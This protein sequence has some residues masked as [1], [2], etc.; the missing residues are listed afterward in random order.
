MP[1][2]GIRAELIQVLVRHMPFVLA[3]LM[4]VAPF[5]YLTMQ[6]IRPER[7]QGIWL[8]AITCILSL[9]TALA[10]A[11][12]RGWLLGQAPR[13]EGFLLV[14]S[15]ASGAAFGVF[16]WLFPI[17][18]PETLV[19][20]VIVL[21]GL[22]SGSVASLTAVRGIYPAFALPAMGPLVL[23][24][25]LL[26]GGFH[27]IIG[28]FGAM[29][30]LVN[31]GYS[32]NQHRALRDAIILRRDRE[33]IVVELEEARALAVQANAAKRQLLLATGHDI[34]Q[35]L[36]GMRL[37]LDQIDT[38]DAPRRRQNVK[39][40]RASCAS[41]AALLDKILTAA[42]FDVGRYNIQRETVPL[43]PLLDELYAEFRPE[44]A[45]R[46][47]ELRLAQTSIVIVTDRI[48]LSQILRNLM[49][50][51]LVHARS[52]R[53][54][55]GV[56]RS[57]NGVRFDVLDQGVGITTTPVE[58]VFEPFFTTRSDPRTDTMGHGLGLALARSMA[59]ALEGE[60]SV[61]S[62]VGCGTRFSLRLASA[63]PITVA[64]RDHP[65]EDSDFNIPGLIGKVLLVEDNRMVRAALRN[66][67]K[68]WGLTVTSATTG[69]SALRKI[70]AAD[71]PDLIISDL[72][73][74][75]EWDGFA[76]V[77]A[78]RERLGSSVPALLITADF[79]VTHPGDANFVI[80]QKPIDPAT[81]QGAARDLIAVANANFR[82]DTEAVW[83]PS[84]RNKL[85]AL[86]L[87]V[88]ML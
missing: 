64:P 77:R 74:A 14:G 13:A 40:L 12:R 24:V 46:K 5:S 48:L 38:A 33:R 75:G 53:I 34:K 88:C 62:V 72:W 23:R 3:A 78:I 15:L 39:T 65:G 42:Q 10:V 11:L 25:M 59:A 57:G 85:Q 67:L 22:T 45:H 1:D 60:M 9:R 81:L 83:H 73:L 31:L 41:M 47:V 26:P 52:K 2:D 54:L 56:R 63:L 44:A 76:L 19:F 17:G 51:A 21:C 27:E 28:L 61:A 87:C 66:T 32:R 70:S 35:P 4:V 71:P 16:G 58:L 80:L 55:F 49:S 86:M 50:N 84:R 68:G 82:Q 20:P 30:L 8:A 6:A 37:L 43:G 7:W 79:T 29:F 18:S 36:F 69:T